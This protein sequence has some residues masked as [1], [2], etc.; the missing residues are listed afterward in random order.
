[1]SADLQVVANEPEQEQESFLFDEFFESEEDKGVELPIRIAGRIVPIR[2]KRGLSNADRAAAEMA[3][4]KR[5]PLPNGGFK[6]LGLDE[7]R[8][9]DEMVVRG[10]VSWPFKNK[11]GSMV[12]I[13]RETVAKLK[14]G[15][16]AILQALTSFDAEGEKA[17]APFQASPAQA[18]SEQEA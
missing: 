1:M 9:A 6:M 15:S 11:D 17:F 4:I 5:Q 12:P 10:I 2:I 7:Q 8:L 18:A 14:G 16:E 3:A 13:T